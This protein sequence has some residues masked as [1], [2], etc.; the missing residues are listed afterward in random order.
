VADQMV[1]AALGT[2]TAGSVIRPAS[3]C[4]VIGYKPTFG[5][6]PMT[7]IKP[8]APSLD[9]LGLFARAVPDFSLLWEALTGHAPP[10]HAPRAPPH[11]ALCRSEQW[12]LAD[13]DSQRVLLETADRLRK[14]GARVDDFELG[15]GFR[16][17]YETQKLIMAVE[18]AR[19]LNPERTGH[20]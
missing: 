19:S 4:G 7:G 9:T 6:L 8:L 1:P 10:P 17:V 12:P 20:L 5:A 3:F 14:T 16:G 11:I 15:E 2:Q 13:A 18:M